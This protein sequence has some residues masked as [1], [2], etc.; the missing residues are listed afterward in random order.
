MTAT[1]AALLALPDTTVSAI[2]A[3]RATAAARGDGASGAAADAAPLLDSLTAEDSGDG[4]KTTLLRS[5]AQH[6]FTIDALART[7]GGGAFE[8][9]AVVRLTG[10]AVRPFAILEWRQSWP[11]SGHASADTTE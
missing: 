5:R 10:D 8:R 7:S 11:S 9:Q 2:M 1:P 4:P 6:A 3:A